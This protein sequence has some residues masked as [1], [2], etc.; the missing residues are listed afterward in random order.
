MQT[1]QHASTRPPERDGALQAHL[2][3]AILDRIRDAYQS[4]QPGPGRRDPA[5]R[6]TV[7][8]ASPLATAIGQDMLEVY[9]DALS[10]LR[11]EEREAIIARVELG[12]SYE[13][14]AVALGESGGGAAR[15]TVQRALVQMA[16]TM[17]ELRK[18]ARDAR[19]P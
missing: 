6:P 19:H 5:H 18:G 3:Q 15:T 1:L 13:E 8:S 17:R 16:A 12:Q 2:R 10:R 7:G 4:A 9:E 14:V 11:P